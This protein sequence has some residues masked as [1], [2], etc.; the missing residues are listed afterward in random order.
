MVALNEGVDRTCGFTNGA[1]PP[2]LEE[3]EVIAMATTTPRRAPPRTLLRK[4][5]YFLWHYVQMCMACCIGGVAL[6]IAFFGGATLLGYPDLIGQ[7]PF[8]STLV[9]GIILTVPMVAWMRLRHHGWRPSLEMGAATMGLGIVLVASGALGLVPVGDMFEWVARLACPV[10][11]VPMLLCV[12]LY[13][14]GMD[15]QEHPPES[16]DRSTS[17]RRASAAPEAPGA[18]I[19][20]PPPPSW[21]LVFTRPRK[22]GCSRKFACTILHRMPSEKRE[23]GF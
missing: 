10:M 15:H 21:S 6:G 22:R 14:G 12:R 5:G 11:L 20:G 16:P 9:L 3:E 19:L 23:D 7:D 17:E 18:R 1:Q 2:I 8:F 4:V 13:A